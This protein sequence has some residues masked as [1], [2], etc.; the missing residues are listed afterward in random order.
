MSDGPDRRVFVFGGFT[1]DVAERV[2]AGPDGAPH[3]LTPR[4]MA[5]LLF[6]LERPD[7]L[8]TK[9][10][11]MDA[12]W[13]DVVVEENS[14]NQVISALRRL[15]G[16][17][18]RVRRFIATVPGLGYRFV[19]PVSLRGR[20]AEA[21]DKSAPSIAVLPFDDLSRDRDQAHLADGVAEETLI[22]FAQIPGLRTIGRTSSFLFRGRSERTQVIGEELG[23][24]YLVTGAVRREGPRI[25]VSAQLIEAVSGAQAWAQTFDGELKDVFAI[26]DEIASSV[27]NAVRHTIAETVPQSGTTSDP[28]AYDLYLRAR[29]A[30]RRTGAEAMTRAVELYRE[31]LDLDPGYALAWAG[32]AEACRGAIIFAPHA[33]D[34]R[35]LLQESAERAVAL[36]PDFWGSHVA[37]AWLSFV[38]YD[39]AAFGRALNE[40]ER[41]APGAPPELAYN[42]AAFL[43]QVGRMND[44]VEQMRHASRGDPLSLQYSSGVQ[45][46]SLSA[47][48]VAE[49]E[50]EY[51]RS[52]DLP[53]SRDLSEL[54]A[55]QRAWL[56][57][58]PGRIEA[59]FRRYLDHRTMPMPA[60]DQVYEARDRPNEAHS[61]LQGALSSPAAQSS[62]VQVILA[63]WL[64]HHGDADAALRAARRG[65]LELGGGVVSWLW[66]PVF[67][68]VRRKPAFK[69]L[70]TELSLVDYWREAGN[71][72]EF[73]R[74]RGDDD[75]ECF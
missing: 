23:A 6:M 13:R 26:E 66:L 37:Q 48:R 46:T 33:L 29:A 70:V 75:F 43:A 8:L 47:G 50:A 19:G 63:W 62:T 61:L 18:G 32:L 16:E 15:L 51:R 64:A 52:L 27:A 40:A 4:P 72:G 39:W 10:E 38:E 7:R 68:E 42:R 2:L 22:R 25:R 35:A 73:A 28:E 11:L 24:R 31:A 1:L 56:D 5:M 71:W 30:V 59:Q 12:V 65:L 17:S 58:E 9:E 67:A 53:G 34:A 3:Q 49:A 44:A 54:A 41:L 55:L 14:L 45:Y 20:A 57:G 69:D 60:L 74:P 21:G 36:A